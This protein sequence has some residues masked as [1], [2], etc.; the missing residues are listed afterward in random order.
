MARE[1]VAAATT[2]AIVAEANAPLASFHYC[3]R[4]KE[5]LLRELT[6]ALVDRMLDAAAA[7]IEPGREFGAMLRDGIRSIWRVVEATADEQ[8]VLYE[9]TQY[10]LRN[11]GLEDLA[12]WQYARYQESATRFLQTI[13]EAGAV[14]WNPPLTVVARMLVA[15]LDGLALGW[16]VERDS[17]EARAA[18]EGFIDGLAL[19]A[20]PQS[21]DSP[22]PLDPV[23]PVLS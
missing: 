5:E 9:L 1:G 7:D 21:A 4:S 20:H 23:P 3:F 19:M 6:P 15:F 17:D 12:T 18:L 2:R 10:A 22:R 14:E 11:P 16:I 8:Q 13:A